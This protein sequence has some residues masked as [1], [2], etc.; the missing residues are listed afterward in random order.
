M[1]VTVASGRV[2]DAF[3]G[4]D[5]GAHTLYHGH[6]FGGNALAAAVALRHLELIDAWDVLANVRE[7]S[8]ELRDLLHDRVRLEAR[9]EGSA[10]A[11]PDG[12]RRAGAPADRPAL[13]PARER[14]SGR[15]GRAAAVDRRRRDARCRRSR[16]PRSELHRIVHVLAEAIDEVTAR[17]THDLGAHGPTA[18][19]AR[20]ATRAAGAHRTTLEPGLVDVVRVERLP[21]PHPASGRARGRARRARSLTARARVGATDRRLAARTRRAR[22]R[23]RGLEAHAAR[24]AVPHRVRHQPRRA[25]HLRR[26]RRVHLLRRAQPRVDHR[27]LPA[28]RADVAVYRHNDLDHLATLLQARGAR[29]R[30]RRDRHRV[31]DGRRRRPTLAALVDL[32]ARERALLVVDEAHAV[33]GP[34][35][36][37][38]SPDARP[39]AG[40]HVVED[41]RRRSA[42]SSRGRHAYVELVEN[43]ARPYI[44]TTAPTPADTAAA[45]AALGVLRSPEGDALVARLR[46][47]VDRLRAGPPVADPALRL[48]RP[49]SEPSP[50]RPRCASAASSCPRSGR[51]RSRPAPRACASRC[52]PRTPKSRS[53]RCSARSPPC[54]DPTH[55]R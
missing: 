3:L 55:L 31:L 48:R 9:G 37:D 8:E 41:A 40:R 2:F 51:R 46:A 42:A 23:A 6:S 29:P 25:H 20:S 52:R 30:A 5:L 38:L 13:G 43:F 39:A 49:R 24:R 19:R 35:L 34:H 47:H 10:A 16:S 32:C 22:T 14:G 33:L 12:R 17:R 1:S 44:F 54:S 28:R 45:L 4:D 21:R 15:A 50:R 7:R 18:R 36:D 11:R 53:T 27:R 26:A